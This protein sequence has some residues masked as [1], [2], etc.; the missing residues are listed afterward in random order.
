MRPSSS[1]SRQ[2][3][4]CERPLAP[5]PAG[6]GG[7]SSAKTQDQLSRKI[8]GNSWG[9]RLKCY[10]YNDRHHYSI[11]A[12]WLG[13]VC[14]RVSG[15][16]R[17]RS[18]PNERRRSFCCISLFAEAGRSKSHQSAS[19]LSVS[20]TESCDMTLQF[21][22]ARGSFGDSL[23]QLSSPVSRLFP[24]ALAGW[25]PIWRLAIPARSP[26]RRILRRPVVGQHP[27]TRPIYL[28]PSGIVRR[29]KPE[30]STSS[31]RS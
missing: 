19:I 7:L 15:N 22:P 2:N 13:C 17:Q 4:W 9:T 3:W 31:M 25:A 28:T 6:R 20:P 29:S 12:E 24:L 26:S 21:D 5:L 11:Y 18:F 27:L 14:R 23:G 1:P 16:G 30:P 8:I 10:I